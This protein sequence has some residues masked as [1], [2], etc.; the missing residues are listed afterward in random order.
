MHGSLLPRS[1]ID[2]LRWFH[3]TVALLPR[4]ESIRQARVKRGCHHL[5]VCE[6]VC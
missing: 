1:L 5:K 3:P 4:A 2:V 6:A